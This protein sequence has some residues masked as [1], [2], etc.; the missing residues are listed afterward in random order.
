ML[1]GKVAELHTREHVFSLIGSQQCCCF[2]FELS[3]I[4]SVASPLQEARLT[5][6]VRTSFNVHIK[7]RDIVLLFFPFS[8]MIVSVCFCAQ[9]AQSSLGFRIMKGLA[10]SAAV[11]L[12]KGFNIAHDSCELFMPESERS[13]NRI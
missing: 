9:A 13:I 2:F 3:S 12:L 6:M 7:R 5:V 11:N 8:L 4:I 10:K 1:A